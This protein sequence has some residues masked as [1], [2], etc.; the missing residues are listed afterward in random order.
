M[1]RTPV[2]Q[3]LLREQP[4]KR[5]GFCRHGQPEHSLYYDERGGKKSASSV[6]ETQIC[7][8]CCAVVQ[9]Y[10]SE[11]QLSTLESLKPLKHHDMVARWL[12]AK[13]IRP[14]VTA[15]EWLESQPKQ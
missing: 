15:A 2:N 13:S 11:A 7:S 9:T 12:T 1:A 8:D 10:F 14:S 5:C 3:Q 6:R 4:R